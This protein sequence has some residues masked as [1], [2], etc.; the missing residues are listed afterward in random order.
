LNRSIKMSDIN[1]LVIIFLTQG[2]GLG[3]LTNIVGYMTNV[4][5]YITREI[6]ERCSNLLLDLKAANK[7]L[8][9]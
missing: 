4:I 9:S 7:S 3:I 8:S 1:R 2:E 6:G 5:G